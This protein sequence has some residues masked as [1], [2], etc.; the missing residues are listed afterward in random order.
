M[1]ELAAGQV[2]IEQLDLKFGHIRTEDIG[3]MWLRQLKTLK[4]DY[5]IGLT[6]EHIIELAKKMPQLQELHLVNGSGAG[7]MTTFTLKEIYEMRP[8]FRIW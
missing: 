3:T 4:L 6:N 8:N 1:Q 2:P 7:Q 5:I